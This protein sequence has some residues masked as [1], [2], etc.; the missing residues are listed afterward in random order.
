MTLVLHSDDYA[1]L[2]R[3]SATEH[4]LHVRDSVGINEELIT[5][6]DRVTFV[7]LSETQRLA[8]SGMVRAPEAIS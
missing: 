8:S 4:K 3:R 7:K 2:E 6:E 1:G 5:H